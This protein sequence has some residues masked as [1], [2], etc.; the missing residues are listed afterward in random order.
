MMKV[1]LTTDSNTSMSQKRTAELKV[2]DS[3]LAI[4]VHAK[5]DSGVNWKAC[6]LTAQ[7]KIPNVGLTRLGNTIRLNVCSRFLAFH[8][9]YD[10]K[11]S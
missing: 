3:N 4:S 7:K 1:S 11:S 5:T 8:T 9:L 2:F 10:N 6:F